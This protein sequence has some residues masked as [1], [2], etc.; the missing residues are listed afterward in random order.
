M[1]LLGRR[2]GY[3]SPVGALAVFG[4]VLGLDLELEG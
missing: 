1:M 4:S 3:E 2:S